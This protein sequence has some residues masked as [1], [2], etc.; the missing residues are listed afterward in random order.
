MCDRQDY[1]ELFFLIFIFY[2]IL[3]RKE[4]F[5]A[6]RQILYGKINDQLQTYQCPASLQG[7]LDSQTFL[8]LRHELQYHYVIQLVGLERDTEICLLPF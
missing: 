6:V 2:W 3:Y 4:F 1:L 7:L 8:C 5:L